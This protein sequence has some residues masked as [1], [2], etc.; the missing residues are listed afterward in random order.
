M[1]SRL[2]CASEL[3]PDSNAQEAY[4]ET[5]GWS[6]YRIRTWY[7]YFRKVHFPADPEI[8]GHWEWAGI[9]FGSK[10]FSGSEEEI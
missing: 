10:P 9:Y 6:Y 7:L 5:W 8:N 3:D 2:R 4:L 1:T